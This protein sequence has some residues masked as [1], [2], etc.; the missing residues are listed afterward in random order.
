MSTNRGRFVWHELMTTDAEA[1]EAFYTHV[2]G[3]QAAD[4]GMPDMRYT[5]LSA[6]SVQVAGLMQM[7]DSAAAAGGRPGWSGF[8]AVEDVDASANQAAAAGATISHP[9]TDIPGVGRFAS[10]KDPQGAAFLLFRSQSEDPLPPAAGTPGLIGWNELYAES[11]ESDFKF[12]AG[13]FGWTKAEALDMGAEGVYQMFAAGGQTIGGMMDRG[14]YIPSPTW[15]YYFNVSDISAASER[16]TTMAGQIL[17]GPT[18]VPGG[19]WIV[20]CLDPQEAMFALVGPK[21]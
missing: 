10:L 4:A 21:V 15:L 3:W 8:V 13:L 18:Q 7:T 1:A 20:Q 17:S 6:G 14:S 5:L 19:S 11:M 9:P 2:V 12:Y 16:V